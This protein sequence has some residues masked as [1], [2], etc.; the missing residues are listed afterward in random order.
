MGNDIKVWI[1]QKKRRKDVGKQDD[2]GSGFVQKFDMDE[3]FCD[4][5]HNGKQ[6]HA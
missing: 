4:Q 2:Q 1:K 5:Q 3:K 6:S